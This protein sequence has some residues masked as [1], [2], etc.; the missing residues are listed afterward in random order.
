MYNK[1]IIAFLLSALCFS[2][3]E[4]NTPDAP[5]GGIDFKVVF[6]ARFDGQPL[7]RY[8]TYAYE[9]YKVDFVRFQ[10]YVSDLTL[11]KTGGGEVKISDV[12]F[13]EFTPDQG[14]GNVAPEVTLTLKNVPE[15]KYTGLRIGYGVKPDMNA[16]KPNSFAADHPLARE[17]EYWIGWSSY[18]FTKIEGRGFTDADEKPDIFMIYHFGS[19]PAYRTFDFTLPIE[20]APNAS[21]SVEWDLKKLFTTSG[22]LMDLKVPANQATPHNKNDLRLTK[23]FVDNFGAATVVK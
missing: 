6:K 12:D 18:I 4:D 21:C 9:D 16:K 2:A 13:I 1:L 3:C 17:N 11:L 15:G 10:T 19:D 7:E 22:K 14:T 23:I 5:T 20:V 8:K